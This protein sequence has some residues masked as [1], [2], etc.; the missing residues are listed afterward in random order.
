MKNVLRHS[1]FRQPLWFQDTGLLHR[2]LE[3][4]LAE[5]AASKGGHPGHLHGESSSE[6]SGFVSKNGLNHVVQEV[7]FS[8]HE[9][10]ISYMR[11]SIALLLIVGKE[12]GSEGAISGKGYEYIAS[13]RPI[14]ATVP[15]SGDAAELIERTKTGVAIQTDDVQGIERILVAF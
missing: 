3:E 5:H 14:I 8:S 1:P 2:G 6:L 9:D 13:G 4:V 11:S 15:V 10:A 12:P 7:P